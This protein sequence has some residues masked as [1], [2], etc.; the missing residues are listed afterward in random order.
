MQASMMPWE[1]YAVGILQ[2]SAGLGGGQG[3]ALMCPRG[4]RRMMYAEHLCAEQLE[5][6][7][8]DMAAI[9]RV[10][11]DTSVHWV[12]PLGDHFRAC[13][14]IL[15]VCTISLHSGM[16]PYMAKGIDEVVGTPVLSC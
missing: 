8:D 9:M 13:H 10:H 11:A 2:A 6:Q 4:G 15:S 1:R 5:V 7:S 16:G 14:L 12:L 3:Q